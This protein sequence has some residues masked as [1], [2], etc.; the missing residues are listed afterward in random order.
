[1]QNEPDECVNCKSQ[2][3]MYYTKVHV[4]GEGYKW[5]FICDDCGH[6]HFTN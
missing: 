4:S 5:A 3:P 1:M 6:A 2:E